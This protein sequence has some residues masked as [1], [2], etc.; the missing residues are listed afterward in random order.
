MPFMEAFTPLLRLFKGMTRKGPGSEA[1]TLR[2][3]SLC[4]LPVRPAI[5][6]LGVTDVGQVVGFRLPAQAAVLDLDEVADP[7]AVAEHR[8]RAQA[9][10]RPDAAAVADRGAVED[11]VRLDDR[12]L[13]DR[14]VA[15]PDSLVQG[16]AGADAAGAGEGDIGMHDAVG[17]DLRLGFDGSAL[18]DG[19]APGRRGR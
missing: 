15:H 19:R 1:S 4:P 2:A 8:P 5:A 9:C 12:I 13:A 11:R 18:G 10:E 6:D 14:R 17:G 7:R 16:R 3:L